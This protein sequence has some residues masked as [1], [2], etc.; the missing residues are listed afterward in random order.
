MHYAG[1]G[2]SQSGVGVAL[3]PS[4]TRY[5]KGNKAS[6][7]GENVSEKDTSPRACR[8]RATELLR[9]LKDGYYWG[10]FRLSEAPLI[11]SGKTGQW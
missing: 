10:S 9:T 3:D 1:E 5:P 7:D 11:P 8:M 4:A 2:R 6:K